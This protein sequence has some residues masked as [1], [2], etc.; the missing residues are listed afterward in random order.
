MEASACANTASGMVLELK[1]DIQGWPSVMEPV[2][3]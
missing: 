1:S 3:E 2:D